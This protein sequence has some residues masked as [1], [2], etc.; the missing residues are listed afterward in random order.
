MIV[1]DEAIVA[2]DIENSLLGLGYSICAVSSSGEE[3]LAAAREKP[4]DLVLMDIMLKGE[5]DGIETAKQITSH[6]GAP[7]VF[8][9]AFS[10]ES[11]IG[12]AKEANAFG[13]L[14]KPFE[15]RELRTTIEMALYKH[16]MELKLKQNREWLETILR[17]I[18]DG[19]LTTNVDGLIEFCNPVAEALTGWTADEMT[20]RRF[21][22]V[23]VL[24]RKR[25]MSAVE[26]NPGLIVRENTCPSPENEVVLINKAGRQIAVECHA[27][28]LTHLDDKILGVVFVLH[29]TTARQKAVAREQMFQRR[30]F[31]AQRMES[32]GML[33]DG[34]AGQLRHIIEP[35]VEYSR[36]M[37]NKLTP[38]DDI[39]QDLTV[40][41][42]SAR[43]AIEILGNL[44]TL[45][46][47]RDYAMEP[48]SLN[49]IIEDTL[50]SPFLR[51]QQQAFPLVEF[52]F[53][54]A[55][56][57][58]VINGCKQNL[59]EMI[60]NLVANAYTA[61]GGTGVVRV[62]TERG[63]I[64]EL[65]SGFEAVE[66][67]EYAVLKIS[68]T[69]PEISEEKINRFFE[70]FAGKSDGKHSSPGNGLGMAVAYAIIKGHKGMIDVQ[71][72]PGKGTEIS[73][74]FPV[75]TG[76]DQV[77]DHSETI[78][79]QGVETVLIVD[80]DADLRKTIM[81]YLRSIGYKVIGAGNGADAVELV[82]KAV[83]G[84]GPAIDLV[85]LDMIMPDGFDGLDTY[86]AMLKFNPRQKAIMASGFSITNRIKN[87]IQLGA[88]ECLLKP[89]ECEEL[90]K[91]V[92]R[93]LDKPARKT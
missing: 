53:E 79:V 33:A 23:V 69:G 67:G 22:E 50:D 52:R 63:K 9:T 8:L 32:L 30:L 76:P 66:T 90:A 62:L 17:S 89:Y 12:R 84:Q 28:P 7:V 68:D 58:P 11:T 72:R 31:R 10:D 26:I 56:Q 64:N 48:L 6:S 55:L 24:K 42:N 65:I 5:T 74:Y 15:E 49:A 3:A 29:D 20:G 59:I 37:V 4:P 85:I 35:I 1:E 45:G 61:I 70:P 18:A 51:E 73:V 27:A 81:G 93:E 75:Y 43:K 40:I 77:A 82:K 78:D 60:R 38:G 41:Q 91:A 36:T 34:V 54:P 14:L 88:G 44:I 13:Y 92:R 21:D 25:D 2:K 80:D 71:S 16:A 83:A 47:M 87:A 39:K 57:P 46:Q 86:T 19:V